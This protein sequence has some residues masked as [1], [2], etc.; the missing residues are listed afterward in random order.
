[1]AQGTPVKHRK[2]T[3]S[4]LK[5]IRQA[6]SRAAINRMN[7]TRVRSV[8]RRMR[9]ALSAA[10]IAEAEK[11]APATF[12]E[13]DK[14]IRKRTLSENTANRY[15]SRLTLALNTLKANKAKG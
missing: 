13:L 1:M 3:K 4:V 6:E 8:M 10:N 15:K 11:L 9:T 5:N 7:R 2:K 12:S 14:A